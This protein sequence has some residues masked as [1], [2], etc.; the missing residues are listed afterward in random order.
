MVREFIIVVIAIVLF[1]GG[2]FYYQNNQIDIEHRI[3][4]QEKENN[5]IPE[6]CIS[7]PD[8]EFTAHITDLSE[9]ERVIPPG[10]IVGGVG[11]DVLKTHSF[12]HVRLSEQVPIYAPVDSALYAGAFYK[13]AGRPQYTLF[14]RVS[15]EVFYVFDHIDNVEPKI[16]EKFSS[17]P[18]EDT[19]TSGEFEQYVH[20]KA[21]ELIGYSEGTP[22]AHSWDFGVYNK[23]RPNFLS[24]LEK[25][26]EY[27]LFPRDKI[28]NCPYDYF[29]Q[30]LKDD[31]TELFEGKSVESDYPKLFCK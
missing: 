1:L 17:T 10:A 21:G 31:Y 2:I 20:V 3:A 23:E 12:L 7:N 13:E 26:K 19:R 8:P 22:Q 18:Q 5:T 9:I 14:F 24:D 28:A 15:C 27:K 25:Y 30:N 29:S 6:K 16:G 4:M 11:G